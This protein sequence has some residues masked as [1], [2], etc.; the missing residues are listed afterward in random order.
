MC[1]AYVQIREVLWQH[2]VEQFNEGAGHLYAGWSTAHDYE[3]QPS[4]LRLAAGQF[5]LLQDVASQVGSFGKRLQEVGVFGY[6]G[7]AEVVV[8]RACC[9]DQEVESH[10]L[11]IV[12]LQLLAGQVDAADA[13]QDEFYAALAP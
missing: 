12:K 7:N 5:E 13:G 8:G 1:L 3:L 6:P 4:R 9:L 2:P 11:A 10:G